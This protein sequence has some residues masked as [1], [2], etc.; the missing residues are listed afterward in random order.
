MPLKKEETQMENFDK[1][2]KSSEQIERK[3]KFVKQN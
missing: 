2:N 1:G 3:E